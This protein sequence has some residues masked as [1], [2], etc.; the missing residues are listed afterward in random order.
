MTIYYTG[1]DYFNRSM[2]IEAD[3]KGYNLDNWGLYP[4]VTDGRV[5]HTLQIIPAYTEHDVFRILGLKYI[6]PT[7]RDL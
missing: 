2:R 4:V 1:G 7:H 5:R 3:K 6:Q